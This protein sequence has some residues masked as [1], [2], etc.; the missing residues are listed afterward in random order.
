MINY[1]QNPVCSGEPR[2]GLACQNPG[3]GSINYDSFFKELELL[4]LKQMG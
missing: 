2:A 1:Q 4:L 3:D